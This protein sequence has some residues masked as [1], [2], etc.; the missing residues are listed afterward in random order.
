MMAGDSIFG[1]PEDFIKIQ[2]GEFRVEKK[3]TQFN[4]FLYFDS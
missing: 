4:T 3:R 1:E 2:I